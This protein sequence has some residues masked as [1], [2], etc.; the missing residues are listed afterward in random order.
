MQ[1]NC[2]AWDLCKLDE[3][4]MSDEFQV[5]SSVFYLLQF[6]SMLQFLLNKIFKNLTLKP[7]CMF[8]F[9]IC[10]SWTCVYTNNALVCLM[11]LCLY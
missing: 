7:P 9:I 4:Y 10:I 5:P 8:I 2:M 11:N 1:L 3:Y 6:K